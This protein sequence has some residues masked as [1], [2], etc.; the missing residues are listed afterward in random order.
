MVF[1]LERPKQNGVFTQQAQACLADIESGKKNSNNDQH[2]KSELKTYYTVS[3]AVLKLLN[4]NNFLFQ[5]ASTGPVSL[6]FVQ[7]CISFYLYIYL[8]D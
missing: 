7:N 1:E 5:T 3:V 6:L 2:L 4:K 8:P